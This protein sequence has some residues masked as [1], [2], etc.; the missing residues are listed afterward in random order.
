MP[1]NLLIVSLVSL[2]T[3]LSTEI[4]FPLLPRYLVALGGGAL[5]LGLME[6]TAESVASL[7]KYHSGRLS[8]R[9]GSRKG[10]TLAGYGFSAVNKL[11][12]PWATLPWHVVTLRAL[13][14][15]GK[16]VGGSPRDALIA[17]STPRASWGFAF[18]LHRAMDTLGALLGPLAA[19]VLVGILTLR[20]TLLVAALP[21]AAGV[22]LL[23]LIREPAH[24]RPRAARPPAVPLAPNQVAYVLTIAA[25][26][27]GNLSLAFLLLRGVE[28]GLSLQ[29]G[30]WVYLIFNATY[31]ALA[32]PLGWITDRWGRAPVV[33]GGFAA[34]ALG[35][36][37]VARIDP[38][39]WAQFLPA[40][41]ALGIGHAGFEGN[42]RALAM[43][44]APAAARGRAIGAYHAAIG[45]SGL[46]AGVL[47]GLLWRVDYRLAYA[48]AA[49]FC[50]VALAE[51]LQLWARGRLVKTS[52]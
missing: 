10:L 19:L 37:L 24:D 30:L 25:F 41:F 28:A 23:L 35:N 34:I 26:T 20:S 18:G 4:G 7:F 21:A 52:F 48:V 50:L 44:L 6:G 29:E 15:V 42:G 51:F 1:R 27:V 5:A 45:F 47:A 13:D 32:F 31:A 22:L 33:A 2:L 12:F 43:D 40:A 17:D 38:H 49:L 36:L 16:G 39:T 8:D 14:R 9:W 46:P 11:G 3:D